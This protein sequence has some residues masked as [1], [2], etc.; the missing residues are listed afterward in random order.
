MI[1]TRV[2]KEENVRFAYLNIFPDQFK[3]DKEK[4]DPSWIKNTMDYFAN[5]AYAQYKKH[6]RTFVKNYDLMKGIIDYT[7]FYQ[8]QPEVQSF[9][10]VLMAN[11]ELPQYVKHYPILNPPVNTM[12][13]ELS[14]RPD[15][16]KVRA[17]DDDSKDEELQ[18]KTGIMQQLIIQEGKKLL[19]NELAMRGEDVSSIPQEE[20]VQLS[21][22][23]VQ[24]YMNTFTTEGEKWGNHVLT[25]LK[26]QFN[27]KEKSE[28][29]FRDLLISSRE[30]F[31]IFEDN[32]K[33][34]FNI[35]VVNPKN[36]WQL[37]TPDAKYT[38]G[39]SGEQN[40]PYAN[41]TV[42]VM[43][44]SEIIEKF[45]E[46]SLEE[47]EHLRKAH[48]D[49]G[50]IN[51][52]ESNLYSGK[53]GPDSIIYDT[54]NRLVLQERMMIESEMKENNDELRD[55]LGLTNTTASFGYKYT[56][57]QS[58][59]LSKKKT[60]LLTYIDEE[61]E[62]QQML[63]DENYKEG[64]PNEIDIQWGWINQW[65]KGT[66]IGPDI[67]F[68]KPFKLLDYSPIIGVTHELK[69]TTAKSLVDLMK[70]FQVLYN[71]CMNQLY[72]LLEKEKGVV[73]A[74]SIR[75]IPTPKDGDGQ[76]ALEIW[77][78]AARKRGV[79]F[80]DDSPENTKGG[81][82]FGSQYGRLDLT[83]T[84]EI[85]SRYR[86]AA[87]LKSECWELIGMNRQRL[88]G[89]LATETATANQNALVQS[90][91]Q[92]EPYFAA[93]NYVVDQLYQAVL[94]AAQ[95]IESNKEESTIS[96]I[97]NL[98]EQAFIKVLGKDLKLKDLKI[99]AT[100]RSEDQQLLNEFRQLSQA[101]M[102]NGASIYDVS[103]LYSTNS[104]RQMQ[105][106]FKDLRDKQEE[107]KKQE[108]QLEQSK[109][110]SENNRVAVT[111]EQEEA[112]FQQDMEMKK[113]VADLNANTKIT[114]AQIKTYFQAP[115]TDTD[116]DGSPDIM[117]IANLAAKNQ[118]ILTKRDIE[119]KKVSLE[120]QKM[121]NDNKQKAEDRKVERENMKNDLA[122]SNN[123]LKAAKAKKP[124]AKKK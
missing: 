46:L 9:T 31:H 117:E 7:D 24:E 30:Y 77:E 35:E 49:Y 22:E 78:E 39:V 116:G 6:R 27:C 105:K 13:G 19:M 52:R 124:A 60:G 54:Y 32:S 108:M 104:L 53:V 62:P 47:I 82:S 63:V 64:S 80:V 4:E 113:Y 73:Q 65:Y 79:I 69:N 122:I 67:F 15:L 98:G 21:I 1:I 55:W 112:H 74:M 37:G 86:L 58:Y 8:Q 42:Q 56:V 50:L 70:P 97:T 48:Q 10:E 121:M 12:I 72:E 111:L 76:D 11:T 87:Q 90:F 16:H 109:I 103:V 14:K 100:S 29:A 93:H 18:F 38:S 17:F 81:T 123:Q 51:V 36:Y 120:M 89:A 75:H 95:Y 59:H 66:K 5:V 71:V 88:G 102:Q 40:V 45:P 92:T 96:Y 28:D 84:S 2:T 33:T 114:E 91:A 20:F 107:M 99:F 61:G 83:R 118:E 101:M 44:I 115:S 23:K 119:N 68:M 110:E 3:T 94:D 34:G 85:E 41:G 106:I 57:V 26:V 25:A 43:E